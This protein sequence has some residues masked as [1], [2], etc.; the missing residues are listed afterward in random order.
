[1]LTYFDT[2]SKKFRRFT[3]I[4][5]IKCHRDQKF[6]DKVLEHPKGA[7]LSRSCIHLIPALTSS[8]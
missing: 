2:G 7:V 5:G 3:N 1:M 6:R 8:N 4:A